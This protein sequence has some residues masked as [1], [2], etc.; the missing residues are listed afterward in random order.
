MDIK[1]EENEE[2]SK[3]P[4]WVKYSVKWWALDKINELDFILGIQHLIRTGVLNPSS[5]EN[6]T[7]ENIEENIAFGV[8]I[9]NYVKQTSLWWTEDKITDEEF[10]DGIQ[11]LIKKGILVI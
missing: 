2:Q 11:Y 1:Y 5:S 3:I 10:V 9:P 6:Q 7:T 4:S 8:K